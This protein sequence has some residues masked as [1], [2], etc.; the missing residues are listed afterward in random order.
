MCVSVCTLASTRS[1]LNPGGCMDSDH[2]GGPHT[3]YFQN[4][5]LSGR[6]REVYEALRSALDL[7]RQQAL[8]AAGAGAAGAS[9]RS[10]ALHSKGKTDA[11]PVTNGGKA[12][13]VPAQGTWFTRP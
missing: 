6:A 9:K 13:S 1:G 2:A 4:A 5:T 12:V 11:A 8:A 7:S 10:S 3:N